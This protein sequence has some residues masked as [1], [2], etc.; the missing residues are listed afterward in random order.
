MKI[1]GMNENAETLRT[2][3]LFKIH[4]ERTR[5]ILC[6]VLAPE[7]IAFNIIESRLEEF[8]KQ[9]TLKDRDLILHDE[10]TNTAM[11]I[12]DVKIYD[13]ENIN[14]INKSNELAKKNGWRVLDGGLAQEHTMQN[15]LIQD[16]KKSPAERTED[17]ENKHITG[18]AELV[19]EL[20]ERIDEKDEALDDIETELS[21]I[22]DIIESIDEDDLKIDDSDLSEIKS[23]LSAIEEKINSARY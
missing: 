2:I 4:M 18:I 23:I 17:L 6:D 22:R 10:P 20:Q 11:V 21:S 1:H 9:L 5:E 3:R 13:P 15:I 7:H 16:Q 12:A 19:D 14:V 8:S